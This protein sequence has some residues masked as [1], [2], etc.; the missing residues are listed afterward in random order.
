MSHDSHANVAQFYFLAIKPQTGLIYFAVHLHLYHIFITLCGS[1]KPYCNG[2]ANG[3]RR[4]HDGLAI[5]MRGY[6][7]HKI[8]DMFKTFA[9]RSQPVCD[10]CEDFSI[11]CKRFETVY[12]LVREFYRKIVAK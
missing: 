11:Q 9:N 7:S 5:V 12:R 10:S 2:S 6:L 3:L 4:D 8:L 1:R